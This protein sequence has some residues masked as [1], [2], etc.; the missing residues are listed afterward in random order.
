VARRSSASEL[1]S[2]SGKLL[3]EAFRFSGQWDELS[4]NEYGVVFGVRQYDDM[5]I[6]FVTIPDKA[7]RLSMDVIDAVA[8]QSGLGRDGLADLVAGY[9]MYK[10]TQRT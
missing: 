3:I 10:G 8:V 1:R 9:R 6:V 5:T 2:V 4:Y 7:G